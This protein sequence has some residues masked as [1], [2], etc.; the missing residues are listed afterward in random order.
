MSVPLLSHP[1]F[2]ASISNPHP[3]LSQLNRHLYRS[4]KTFLIEPEKTDLTF[5]GFKFKTLSSELQQKIFR[6]IC[7]QVEPGFPV[8]P[9]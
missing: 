1:A 5:L 3:K 6:N 7:D 9:P 8:S 2:L 4:E